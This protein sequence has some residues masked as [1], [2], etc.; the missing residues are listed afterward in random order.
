MLTLEQVAN[1]SL[2]KLSG[3]HDVLSVAAKALI[4]NCYKKGIY[5]QITQG[6]RSIDEQND[7]YAQGRTKQGS[8]VTNAKGGYSY[9]NFGLAIDFVLLLP[10]GKNV[11]WDMNTDYNS[12]N[13]KDWIEV[14]DEAKRLGFEWGG[15]WTSFKDYPHFQ[16]VF[17]LS[18]ADLRNG[19]KPAQKLIDAALA[20]INKCIQAVPALVKDEDQSIRPVKIILTK[21]NSV[22]DGLLKDNTNFVPISV[23]KDLGHKVTWDNTNK[24]LYIS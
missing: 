13:M 19:K 15:D 8:I 18:T 4:E 17:G 6:L 16:M 5:I 23:L 7:L 21:D 12:N 11:T 1:K 2:K 22:R 14:V 3:L 10:D 24:K 9:H 20:Q